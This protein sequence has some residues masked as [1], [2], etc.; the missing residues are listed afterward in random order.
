MSQKLNVL[1][2]RLLA[3]LV[4]GSAL[5]VVTTAAADD[6]PLPPLPP[7]PPASAPEPEAAP[8][9]ATPAPPIFKTS[10]GNPKAIRGAMGKGVGSALKSIGPAIDGCYKEAIASEGE[11][12]GT[13]ELRLEIVGPGRVASATVTTSENLSSTLRGCVRDAFAGAP[14]G[15]IGP[16]PT[17]V[18]LSIAFDR[19]V[20]EDA[21]RPV[22]ACPDSCE[23]EMTDDLRAAIRERAVRASFC[24]K[25]S[26][27]AGEPTTLKPGELHVDLRVAGDGSVCGVSTNNDTFGRPSLTSCV[28]EAMSG[29]L[30]AKPIGCVDVSIPIVFKGT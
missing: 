7:T 14:A 8:K 29:T 11:G 26:A 20:P 15:A 28:V 16:E 10:I 18:V 5:F 9:P 6:A 30:S 23:G 22:S 19:D 25:R 13:M 1:S 2:K 3:A 24:F 4:V 17:E 12:E 21:V 27:A